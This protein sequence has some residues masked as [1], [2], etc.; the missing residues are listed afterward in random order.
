MSHLRDNIGKKKTLR[1]FVGTK[2]VMIMMNVHRTTA[3]RILK[4]IKV[5]L[6]KKD[7]HLVTVS[8]F[9]AVFGIDENLVQQF[10]K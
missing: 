5:A 9:A 1:L 8:E 6:G 4:S 3:G 7:H 10:L 2:D